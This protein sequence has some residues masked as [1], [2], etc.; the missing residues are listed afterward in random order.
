M[1][2]YCHLCF[3]LFK[4]ISNL[5]YWRSSTKNIPTWCFDL[6]RRNVLH[7]NTSGFRFHLLCLCLHLTNNYESSFIKLSSNVCVLVGKQITLFTSGSRGGRTRRAHPPNG[8]GPMIFLCPKRQFFSCFSSL[9]SLAIH[10]K[11]NLNR[12]MAKTR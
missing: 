3:C 1:F 12:Y 11:S 10:F 5:L 2:K 6:H 8:R 4:K 9:A 7:P